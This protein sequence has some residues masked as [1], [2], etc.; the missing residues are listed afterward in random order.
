MPSSTG[1]VFPTNPIQV[2]F[3]ACTLLNPKPD[4]SGVGYILGPI[5]ASSLL[6]TFPKAQKVSDR[7]IAPTYSVF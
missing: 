5:C 6:Q 2:L 1:Q 3:N 4:Q 7:S